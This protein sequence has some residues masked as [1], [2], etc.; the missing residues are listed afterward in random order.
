MEDIQN[1]LM[2]FSNS[3]FNL[4][5]R[6]KNFVTNGLVKK[7]IRYVVDRMWKYEILPRVI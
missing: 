5:F 7:V 2:A 1:E 3:S 4:I 6:N